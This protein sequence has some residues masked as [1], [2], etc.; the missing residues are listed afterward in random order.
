M[1]DLPLCVKNYLQNLDS[2]YQLSGYLCL[3]DNNNLVASCGEIG[4]YKFDELDKTKEIEQLMPFMEG[5]V[6]TTSKNITV[7]N[8]V[9]IDNDNYF[10]IHFVQ[11]GE[12]SWIL[13]ID[14]TESAT[15]LQR[16]QQL[17]LDIDFSND[18]RKTGS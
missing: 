12:G 18:R 7:I 15:Q 2:N 11:D 13:F 5:I 14:T 3:D 17:R 4:E 6:P 8:N 16:E 9:H 10:D 1:N